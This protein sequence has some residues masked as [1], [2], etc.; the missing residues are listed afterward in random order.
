MWRT[1]KIDDLHHLLERNNHRL[2]EHSNL[3][4]LIPVIL[5]EELRL[6]KTELKQPGTEEGKY[7]SRELSLI[8]DGST[9]LGEAIAIIVRLLDDD[10][11]I[12]QRLIW[13]DVVAHAVTGEQLAQVLQ[14]CLVDFTIHGPRVLG[15]TR[16]SA[17]VNGAAKD[18]LRPFC[19]RMLEFICVSHTLDNVGFHFDTPTADEF[20]Q[21]WIRIFTHSH[22]A[23]IR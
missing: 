6:I 11:K 21:C 10:W 19:P 22:K 13:L 17:S 12:Q 15:F 4:K 23:K 18:R 20:V 5:Q 9:R 7:V 1:R 16:D 2:T 8:F 3:L 14:G